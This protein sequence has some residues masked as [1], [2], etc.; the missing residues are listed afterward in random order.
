MPP[1]KVSL[2]S[3]KASALSFVFL[4]IL[5]SKSLVSSAIGFAVSA[6][7]PTGPSGLGAPVAV[8]GNGGVSLTITVDGI[9][10][11]GVNAANSFIVV[12]DIISNFN[13]SSNAAN[14]VLSSANYAFANSTTVTSPN[15]N[16]RIVDV[17]GFQTLSVGPI[18]N[19]KVLLT[20]G[21]TPTT[22]AL[23][24]FGAPYGP[25]GALR[26]P[27]SLRSIGK[28]KVNNA[29]SFIANSE[30]I[31]TLYFKENNIS[32]QANGEMVIKTIFMLALYFTPYFLML[33]G[34]LQGNLQGFRKKTLFLL[35]RKQLGK[36]RLSDIWN[37]FVQFRLRHSQESLKFRFST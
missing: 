6:I 24:A 12:T 17:L 5:R 13:G 31:L 11:S 18:T 35:Q 9:D 16:T 27:K 14:T 7:F 29:D 28:I 22:P 19:V 2:R 3:V 37:T 34:V 15:L 10:Q 33:T 8:S 25:L 4:A 36:Y 1:P 26:S 32:K 20:S 30:H 21:A 23:D